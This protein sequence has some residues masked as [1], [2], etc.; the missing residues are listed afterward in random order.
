MGGSTDRVQQVQRSVSSI[1]AAAHNGT[2]NSIP[3]QR[4][5]IG[6]GRWLAFM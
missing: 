3:N 4:P 2:Q 1:A 6:S 5:S